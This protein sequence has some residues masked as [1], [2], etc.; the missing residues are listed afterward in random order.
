MVPSVAGDEAEGDE[1]DGEVRD[2]AAVPP[3]GQRGLEVG[4]RGGEVAP[5]VGDEAGAVVASA[6]AALVPQSP[7]GGHRSLNQGRRL[8][9]ALLVERPQAE[10]VQRSRLPQ[11]VAVLAGQRQQSPRARSVARA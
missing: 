1:G 2:A 8:V 5:P 9:V 10:H 4:G 3:P 11:R 6:D 7:V